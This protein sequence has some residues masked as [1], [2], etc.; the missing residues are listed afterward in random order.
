[1][2]SY[3]TDLGEILFKTASI[4]VIHGRWR[5]SLGRSYEQFLKPASY[6][7][8]SSEAPKRES[9]SSRRTTFPNNKSA[10]EA[11]S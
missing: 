9:N 10:V 5:G 7:C 11:R 8:T 2:L 3:F 6:Q 4:S 1:M